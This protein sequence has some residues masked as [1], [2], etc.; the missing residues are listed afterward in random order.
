MIRIDR[1]LDQSD[2]HVV[3]NHPDFGELSVVSFFDAPQKNLD[4]TLFLDLKKILGDKFTHHGLMVTSN[5]NRKIKPANILMAVCEFFWKNPSQ[6]VHGGATPSLGEIDRKSHMSAFYVTHPH[7]FNNDYMIDKYLM[8]I[9]ISE[10][11]LSYLNKFGVTA[12]ERHFQEQDIDVFDVFR[13][14][15]L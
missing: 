7:V 11:E 14:S 6:L 4:T 10:E 8:F 15:S 1:D 2:L 13:R 5:S 3:Y 12:L 9:A